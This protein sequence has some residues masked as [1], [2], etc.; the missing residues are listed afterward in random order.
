MNVLY[1]QKNPQ[2]VTPADIL[3]WETGVRGQRV[4]DGPKR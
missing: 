3:L 1:T 2:G 4:P